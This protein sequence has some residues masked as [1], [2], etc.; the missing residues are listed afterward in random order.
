LQ[1]NRDALNLRLLEVTSSALGEPAKHESTALI[2]TFLRPV[3][4]A[5][6]RNAA[7]IHSSLVLALT[8]AGC[9]LQPPANTTMPSAQT[10]WTNAAPGVVAS[11]SPGKFSSDSA[12]WRRL[13]DD[14]ITT[15]IDAADK[16]SPT[17]ALALARV[18]EARASISSTNAASGPRANVDASTQRA[19][20][21]S[22]S[23]D[24]QTSSSLNLNLS[25]ELDLFGRLRHNT[26]AA[27]QRLASRESD[28]ASTRLTLHAQ[29]AE[30]VLNSR[31]CTAKLA[32]R[33]DDYRSRQ[34]TLELTSLRESVGQVAPIDTARA[35]SALADSANQL[36]SNKMQCAQYITSLVALTGLS[37]ERIKLLLVE[38]HVNVARKIPEPPRSTLALPA[39]VLARHPSVV[40]A[41]RN[42]DAAYE[43]IGGAEAARLPSLS[44]SGLLGSTWLRAAG[45]STRSTSWSIGPSLTGS[46]WDGGAGRANADA[47]RARHAEAIAQLESAVRNAAE[48][49]ENA[50]SQLASAEAREGYSTDG[51]TASQQLLSGSEASFQVGRMSLFELEDTRRTYNNAVAAY[52]DAMRD[53]SLAWVALVKATA[54]AMEFA[55]PTKFSD[56]SSVIKNSP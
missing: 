4:V 31:A 41:L 33:Q 24:A 47:A 20:G 39:T 10:N 51:L 15:L 18:D 23:G 21:Q 16:T 38:T 9:A 17:I 25:W 32:A 46:L 53:R 35:R 40:T 1:A 34:Q 49:I 36:S 7:H 2:K 30:A 28:A 50:L 13:R 42:A 52:V 12:W 14:A 26:A 48:E 19:T 11:A 54:N 3:R 45:T 5:M 29:V 8:L 43:D 55:P 27:V 37:A 56:S 22:L 6:S 44:L